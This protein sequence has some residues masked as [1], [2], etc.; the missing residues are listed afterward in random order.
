MK[1]PEICPECGVP[2][3]APFGYMIQRAEPDYDSDDPDRV[4]DTIE[5]CSECHT[6]FRFR[7]KLES[8]HRLKEEMIVSSKVSEDGTE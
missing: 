5:E 8:I 2:M 6:L 7:W 3:E 4:V 1:F